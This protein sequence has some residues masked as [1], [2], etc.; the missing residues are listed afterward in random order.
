MRK[1]RVVTFS[2]LLFG[3]TLAIALGQPAIEES[4]QVGSPFE[5]RL[6][7][8]LLGQNISLAFK[9]LGRTGASKASGGYLV[10]VWSKS[11]DANVAASARDANS[12]HS[13]SC[14]IRLS[15]DPNGFIAFESVKD[16]N[17]G[18]H[19]LFGPKLD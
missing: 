2:V 18:C 1:A 14:E 15:T 17:D 3:Y 16:K 12:D 19:L 5:R 13:F 11:G 7:L 6:Q 9:R 8:V 10:Y 4:L